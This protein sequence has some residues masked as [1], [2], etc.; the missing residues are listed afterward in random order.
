MKARRLDELATLTDAAAEREQRR[1]ASV[2]EEHERL[3]RQREELDEHARRYQRE[4]IESGRELAVALLRQRR[5]FVEMLTRR[6]TDMGEES[7]LGEQRVREAAEACRTAMA[8]DAALDTLRRRA[9]AE[10]A[11]AAAREERRI[12]DEAARA[13]RS[14]ASV[15]PLL[16]HTDP[17]ALA[18][19]LGERS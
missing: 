16:A 7:R 6:V 9:S 18:D 5:G 3:L 10:H 4:P 19:D 8:R 2:R 12:M 11:L 13:C 17:D 14:P 1:L 15:P